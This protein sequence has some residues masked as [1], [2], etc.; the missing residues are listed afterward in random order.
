MEL[1]VGDVDE[2]RDIAAQIQQGVELYRSSGHS[3]VGPREHG[4]TQV[5]SRRIPGIDGVVQFQRKTVVE[6]EL[7]GS[8]DQRLSKVGVNAP[9]AN[10]VRV[11]KRIAGNSTA[12]PHVV[13][14]VLLGTQAGFDIPETFAVGQ[15]CEGHAEVMVESGILL[16][17]EVAIVT[18]YAA[19]E[20]MERKM[21]HHLGENEFAGVHGSPLRTVLYEDGWTFGQ[22]S[23]R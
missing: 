11:G 22:F 13:Q 21:F 12:Y 20:D 6:V 2:G 4:K 7:P 5:D 17:L 9:V 8:L 18:I 14:L 15:L 10:L 1:A 16:D 19:M 23:S 3:E